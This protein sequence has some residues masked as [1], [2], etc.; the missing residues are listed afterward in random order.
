MVSILEKKT[1]LCHL[2]A[3]TNVQ[4]GAVDDIL[5]KAWTL[6]RFQMRERSSGEKF[7]HVG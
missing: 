7:L 4:G 2:Q 6:W 1:N 3:R 5:W